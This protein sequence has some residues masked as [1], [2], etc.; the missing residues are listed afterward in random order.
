MDTPVDDF[1]EE[2]SGFMQPVVGSAVG[3]AACTA[4][5]LA[6]E[7]SAFTLGR[8]IEKM[9][10]A[11]ALVELTFQGATGVRTGSRWASALLHTCVVTENASK[12]Q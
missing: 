5:F 11:V 8:G 7:A 4:T 3:R 2:R 10:N 1:I 9:A 12:I 6:A